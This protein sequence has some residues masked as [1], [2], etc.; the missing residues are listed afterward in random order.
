MAMAK[1]V[2]MLKQWKFPYRERHGLALIARAD[3]AACVRK[4]VDSGCRFY[5]YDSFIISDNTIQPVSDLSADWSEAT[6]P[7]LHKILSQLSEH[8]SE[9]THYEF[10]F[11]GA[12]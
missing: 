10:V 9:I 5:G 1:S 4:I 2:E 12:G 8:P 6:P 11:E 3:A 7:P